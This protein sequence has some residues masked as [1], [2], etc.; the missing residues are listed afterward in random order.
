[1]VILCIAVL[2]SARIV[3]ESKTKYFG[4][5]I[6]LLKNKKKNDIFLLFIFIYDILTIMSSIS[7]QISLLNNTIKNIND[8]SIDLSIIERYKLIDQIKNAKDKLIIFHSNLGVDNVEQKL[9]TETLELKKIS[10]TDAKN[11]I[12]HLEELIAYYV[13]KHILLSE[14]VNQQTFMELIQNNLSSLNLYKL[15]LER[16]NQR[17]IVGK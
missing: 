13:N 8:I 14:F 5:K 2:C 11:Y 1:M 12:Q 10:L 9:L 16:F 17:I 6:S 7:E 15:E 4:N 3:A